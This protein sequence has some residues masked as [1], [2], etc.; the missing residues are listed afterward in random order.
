MVDF[1]GSKE[2]TSTLYVRIKMISGENEKVLHSPCIQGIVTLV[3]RAALRNPRSETHFKESST[4]TSWYSHRSLHKNERFFFLLQFT[5]N[6]IF[7][8]VLFATQ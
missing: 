1:V 7:L 3:R 6:D 4:S 2:I 8:L 5:I